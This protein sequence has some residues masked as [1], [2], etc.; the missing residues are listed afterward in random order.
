[1]VLLRQDGALVGPAE[2]SAKKKRTILYA[3]PCPKH[4]IA[5]FAWVRRPARRRLG[6]VSRPRFSSVIE[7][8]PRYPEGRGVWLEV[9]NKRDLEAVLKVA[10]IKMANGSVAVRTHG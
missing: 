6:P 1:M 5:A 4:F 7:E 9:R 2:G 8:A 10:S 3:I